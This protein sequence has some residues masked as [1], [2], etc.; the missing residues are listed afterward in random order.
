[1]GS[2]TRPGV[3]EPG[4]RARRRVPVRPADYELFA[5]SWGT[6]DDPGD[7]PIW[8]A[9]HTKPRYLASTTLTDPGWADTTVL[10]GDLAAAVG[11]LEAKP[12]GELQV[13]G[14]GALVCWLLA[15]GWSTSSSC[16]SAR[17]S[18]V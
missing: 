17:W 12:G 13:H 8:T 15:T 9:L 18:S 6:W 1:M 7:S 5:G 11:G 10:S 3:P 16:W 4:L 2:T 14:S